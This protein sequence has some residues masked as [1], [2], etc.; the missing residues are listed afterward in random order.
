[1]HHGGLVMPLD[2]YRLLKMI[3]AADG[4]DGRK[5]LQKLIYL[6]QIEGFATEDGFFLHYYGPYSSDLAARIDDLS[7]RDKLLEQTEPY[8]YTVQPEARTQLEQY[9]GMLRERAPEEL[10]TVDGWAVRFRELKAKP[11][12]ELE[13][14]ATMVYWR[15][16]GTDWDE[17][18]RNTSRA[19]GVGPDDAG[20]RAARQLADDVWGRRGT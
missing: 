6:L 4:I 20:F 12:R 9:D 14:A 13:L 2:D 7:R 5:R 15:E 8:R 11:V 3:D 18:E 16:W 17:A 1:M 19:K 10:E